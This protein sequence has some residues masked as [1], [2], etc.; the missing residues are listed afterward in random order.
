M[1]PYVPLEQWSE[2]ILQQVENVN[3]KL[4]KK[5]KNK[6]VDEFGIFPHRRID[7]CVNDNT[8]R[9]IELKTPVA[10]RVYVYGVESTA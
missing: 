3:L 9:E 5:I 2:Y 4:R 7:W 8:V 10:I 6:N 1:E